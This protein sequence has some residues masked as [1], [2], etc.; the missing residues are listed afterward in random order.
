MV[1]AKRILGLVACVLAMVSAFSCGRSS[2]S[3]TYTI[4]TVT[5]VL[6]PAPA[7]GGGGAATGAAGGSVAGSAAVAPG[8]PIPGIW[9]NT[10][11][12]VS[13]LFGGTVRS[14]KPYGINFDYTDNATQF[15][16]IEFTAIEV[17]Y[18]NGDIEPAA[19]ALRLP[20]R[21]NARD[22]ESVNSVSG[23]RIVRSIS[24]ILS[25]E[26]AGVITRDEAFRLRLEGHFVETN[27]SVVPFVIDQRYDIV[28]EQTTKPAGEVMR[29]G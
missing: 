12:K 1:S 8:G 20:R 10:N 17:R 6:A 23:G 11:T 24:R 19:A 29:D 9:I 18:D 26:L 14:N 4:D 27:G 28:I 7:A 13:G 15:A 25:G 22:H 2:A 5:F 21:T 16:A 3:G